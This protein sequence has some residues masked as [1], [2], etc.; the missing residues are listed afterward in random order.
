MEM[1][2]LIGYLLIGCINFLWTAIGCLKYSDEEVTQIVLDSDGGYPQYQYLIR[3][4]LDNHIYWV[5]H[6]IAD[7]VFWPIVLLGYIRIHISRK[8]NKR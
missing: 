3:M 8:N 4:M 1:I 7:I 5:I 2:Y 6:G